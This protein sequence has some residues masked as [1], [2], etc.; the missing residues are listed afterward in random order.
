MA[1]LPWGRSEPSVTPQGADVRIM[2]ANPISRM[3]SFRSARF[4]THDG[5]VVARAGTAYEIE[6]RLH[7]SVAS[8]GLRVVRASIDG[9][10]V[11]EQL[12]L[13]SRGTSSGRFVGWLQ[14]ATG[15]KRIRFT[16]PSTAGQESN[17][18]VGVFAATEIGTNGK[19]KATH[20]PLPPASACGESFEGPAVGAA[21]YA[22]GEAVA[23][24][25]ARLRAEP[26]G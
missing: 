9:Q 24:G 12:V 17:V 15:A 19:G 5:V 16:F 1:A 18:Q 6:V 10:E 22:L 8:G 4:S 14:D 13:G 11:N 23:V 20:V 21:Q 7:E 25:C 26:E 3:L 2:P